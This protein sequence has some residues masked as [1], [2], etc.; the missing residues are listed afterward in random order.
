MLTSSPMPGHLRLAS[1]ADVSLEDGSLCRLLS[2]ITAITAII[3]IIAIRRL[4]MTLRSVARVTYLMI[5]LMDVVR[6]VHHARMRKHVSIA[7]QA[8]HSLVSEAVVCRTR[9]KVEADSGGKK[10]ERVAARR[11]HAHE[12]KGVIETR[13]SNCLLR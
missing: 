12:T 3:A 4:S 10:L 2:A 13:S 1:L 7:A 6:N 11:H 9:G 8:K 5:C